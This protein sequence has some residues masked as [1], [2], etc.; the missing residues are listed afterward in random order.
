MILRRLWFNLV[1][2]PCRK[3]NYVTSLMKYYST[4]YNAYNFGELSFQWHALWHTEASISSN[5][6][7]S[8]QIYKLQNWSI[9]KYSSSQL[10]ITHSPRN[11]KNL[12]TTI[13]FVKSKLFLKYGMRLW[14]SPNLISYNM[15][16]AYTTLVTSGVVQK[17]RHDFR[18]RGCE[19]FCDDS[20][21]AL[22]MKS[23]TMGRGCQKW[24][25]FAWRRLWMIP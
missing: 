14:I 8:F 9:V 15:R 21:K 17:W 18:G 25:K 20:T 16:F 11:I 23:V 12:L 13:E 4:L 2:I 5:A 3:S 22:V 19:W 6:T 1:Q 10:V 7:I 24:F